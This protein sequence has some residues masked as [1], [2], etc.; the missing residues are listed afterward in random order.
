MTTF[1]IWETIHQV[2]PLIPQSQVVNDIDDMQKQFAGETKLLTTRALLSSISTNVGWALPSDFR[3][4]DKIVLYDSS[5]NPKYLGDEN[6]SYEIEFGKF[7]IYSLTETPITGIPTS[8]ASIYLHYTKYPSTISAVASSLTIDEEFT[9]AILAGLLAKYFKLFPIDK[10]GRDGNV[11]K[12]FMLDVAREWEREYEKQR[13]KA[14]RKAN[15][16]DQTLSTVQ[17]YQHAGSQTLPRRVNDDSSSVA[18]IGGI[19]ATY[20]KY[21]R[22][23]VTDPSTVTELQTPVG[24]TITSYTYSGGTTLT[25]D[26][27]SGT[28]S[29]TD[30]MIDSS[31]VD[32][33]KT[34]LTTSQIVIDW[35]TAGTRT[36][37]VYE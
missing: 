28:F 17:N 14:K 31:D 12:A 36:I 7:F 9:P 6:L 33:V 29:L 3:S 37:E 11:G 16:L 24:Y 2:F 26:A 10:V 21:L 1:Q 15:E 19:T 32:Y 8:I 34:T 23:R 5:S 27:P 30:T 35:T 25:I 4:L 20:T 13:I 18:I 22:L